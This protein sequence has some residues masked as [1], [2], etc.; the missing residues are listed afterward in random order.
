[1]LC[2]HA[3]WPAAASTKGACAGSDMQA[4]TVL[5]SVQV[6][7]RH[8]PQQRGWARGCPAPGGRAGRCGS[9]WSRGHSGWH[10]CP[11]T[12]RA[13]EVGPDRAGGGQPSAARWQCGRA[14]A[15]MGQGTASTGWA[16]QRKQASLYSSCAHLSAVAAAA[17][18]CSCFC[19]WRESQM[20]ARVCSAPSPCCCAG[21]AFPAEMA[22]GREVSARVPCSE[23]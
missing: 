14:G 17:A 6:G 19:W 1:M 21:P 16:L 3:L 11:P 2:N 4:V 13:G 9:G 12:C 10:R 23:A 22:P 7:A 15:N 5:A 18:C 8:A 20:A